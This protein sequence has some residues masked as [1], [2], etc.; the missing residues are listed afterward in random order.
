MTENL[1][2]NLKDAESESSTVCIIGRLARVMS[3]FAGCDDN[4]QLGV[5]ESSEI[6]QNKIFMKSGKIREKMLAECSPELIDKYNASSECEEVRVLIKNIKEKINTEISDEYDELSKSNSNVRDTIKK[7][8]KES[9]S[10][11]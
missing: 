10:C 3:T 11:I 1:I 7:A 4:S 9:Q 8:I 2:L 6:I 5:L